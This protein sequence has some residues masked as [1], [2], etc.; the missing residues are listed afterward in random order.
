MFLDIGGPLS[1]KSGL[2]IMNIW[3]IESGSRQPWVLV[4]QRRGCG[5]M[6]RQPAA[7][8]RS[9]RLG[10]QPAACCGKIG[11]AGGAATEVG[12]AVAVGQRQVVLR[13]VGQ[14]G[15]GDERPAEADQVGQPWPGLPRRARCT[16]RSRSGCHGRRC[17][18]LRERRWHGRGVFPVGLG[19][20]DVAT[21]ISSSSRAALGRWL[22]GCRRPR[23]AGWSAAPGARRCA[24]CRPPR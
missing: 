15:V 5:G 8:S 9:G 18:T 7:R 16:C 4:D 6:F 20:V 24:P 12:R 13:A 10:F 1:R 17:A 3:R 19:D 23:P 2:L 21:P 22:A 14:V 11:V